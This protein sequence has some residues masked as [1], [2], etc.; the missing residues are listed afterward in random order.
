MVRG[1]GIG[2]PSMRTPVVPIT[3]G[4]SPAARNTD[5]RRYVVVVLPL[6][7]VIPTTIIRSAG[8]P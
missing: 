1:I 3:P 6:V 7:P 2:R 4:V 8:R 5:S